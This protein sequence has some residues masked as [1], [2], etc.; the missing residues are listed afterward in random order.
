MSLHE[1]GRMSRGGVQFVEV[2]EILAV[3]SG[4]AV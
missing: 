1:S 2:L 3:S 4:R